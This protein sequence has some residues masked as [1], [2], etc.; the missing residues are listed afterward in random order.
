MNDNNLHLPIEASKE[1][2]MRFTK[3][4]RQQVLNDNEGFTTSTY[5]EAKNFRESRRYTISDG[6]LNVRASGK[7]SWS[8]SRY[9]NEYEY[10]A[11]DEET[12]RFLRKY[13]DELKLNE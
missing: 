5:F 11:D 6:K 7:T 10:G 9:D 13:R 12:K 3:E 1:D 8:D 4:N 2:N